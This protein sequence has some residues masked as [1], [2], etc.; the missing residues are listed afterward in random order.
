MGSTENRDCTITLILQIVRVPRALLTMNAIILLQNLHVRCAAVPAVLMAA[1]STYTL[2]PK[3]PN[4][5]V[6]QQSSQTEA[7]ITI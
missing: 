1:L 6:C 2:P 7:G 3:Q 5:G 4:S